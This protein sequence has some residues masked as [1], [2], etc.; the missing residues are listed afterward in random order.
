MANP[1]ILLHGYSDTSKGFQK[2]R[3]ALIEKKQLDPSKVH[4]I[5]Y[6]SLANEITIRDI[7]EAFDRALVHE[8]GIKENDPHEW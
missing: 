7:A 8:A 3:D 1:L 6:V 5:N 4:L 2:W